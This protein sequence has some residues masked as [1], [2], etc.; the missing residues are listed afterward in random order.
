MKLF[1]RLMQ[2]LR[3]EAHLFASPTESGIREPLELLRQ[4]SV[5]QKVEKLQKTL[6]YAV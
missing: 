6:K 4:Q 1:W 2:Y 3:R 5:G